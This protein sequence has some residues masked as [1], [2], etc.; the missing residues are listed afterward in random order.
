MNPFRCS[1]SFLNLLPAAVDLLVVELS[2]V[3]DAAFLTHFDRLLQLALKRWRDP[4][5]EAIRPGERQGGT[6]WRSG[7]CVGGWREGYRGGSEEAECMEQVG[8]D[9]WL[10]RTQ[11]W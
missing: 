10:A 2:L 5:L 9:V 4:R 7:A 3:E 8:Q 1:S 11:Q 6:G